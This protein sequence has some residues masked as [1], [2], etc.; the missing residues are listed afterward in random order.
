MLPN[1]RAMTVLVRMMTLYGMLKSGVGSDSSSDVVRT[2]NVV[3]YPPSSWDRTEIIAG[4]YR[5]SG[6][7]TQERERKAL[8][9]YRSLG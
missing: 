5:V 6:I 9:Q 7:H 8:T 2:E 1:A 3:R 4:L